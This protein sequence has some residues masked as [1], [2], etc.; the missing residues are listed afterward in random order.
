[1]KIGCGIIEEET[2]LAT[3]R[4]FTAVSESPLAEEVGETLFPRR[5]IVRS[6]EDYEKLRPGDLTKVQI[7]GFEGPKWMVYEGKIGGREAFLVQSKNNLTNMVSWRCDR[8]QLLTTETLL[9]G[10]HLPHVCSRENYV[11]TL[12]IVNYGAKSAMLRR[13]GL[14]KDVVNLGWAA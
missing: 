12:D 14:W 7:Y 4:D 9:G 5:I 13:A 3:L 11:Y 6:E 2:T 1:M 10:I 8:K